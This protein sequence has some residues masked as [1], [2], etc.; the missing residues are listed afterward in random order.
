MIRVIY[1]NNTNS[2]RTT[3]DENMTVR[4]FLNEVSLDYS[5]GMIVMDG[6]SVK[7]GDLDKTFASMG[8]G[9]DDR[10]TCFI[11]VI[12]KLDNA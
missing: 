5:S 9:T 11:A 6:A 2:E 10:N 8:Y 1:S 12:K 3:T 4:S 7:P